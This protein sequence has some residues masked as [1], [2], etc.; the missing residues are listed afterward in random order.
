MSITE[1]ADRPPPENGGVTITYTSPG[2]IA[3]KPFADG[4]LAMRVCLGHTHHAEDGLMTELETGREPVPWQ[5]SDVRNE[6]IAALRQRAKATE[7][8]ER[9]ALARLVEHVL[10]TPYYD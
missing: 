1:L 2:G 7:A 9:S 10:A 5:N 6:A 4:Y 3:V 8:D